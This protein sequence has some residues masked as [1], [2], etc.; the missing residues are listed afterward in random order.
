M[1]KSRSRKPKFDV[2]FKNVQLA[3][4][5]P[6]IIKDG[7]ALA[8]TPL[9]YI[10]PASVFKL[11][12]WVGLIVSFGIT[13]L[14]GAFFGLN[15]VKTGAF[16]LAGAHIIWGKGSGTLADMGITPWTLA[17]T[18]TTE[19]KKQLDT[20]TGTSQ[21]ADMLRHRLAERL[22]GTNQRGSVPVRLGNVAYQGRQFNG[23]RQLAE[24]NDAMFA[25]P[26]YA[27]EKNVSDGHRTNNYNRGG[28]RR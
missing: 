21:T 22:A 6:E 9:L 15:R 24:N 7:I 11:K 26:G 3:V 10:I 23:A 1:A 20:G 27:M 13:W 14:T 19:E 16:I 17:D 5:Q 12:G 4:T 25:Q 2:G 18:G 8:L 28:Y